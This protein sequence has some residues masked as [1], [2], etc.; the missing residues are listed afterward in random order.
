MRKLTHDYFPHLTG[1]KGN[2][3]YIIRII[4]YSF[5][6]PREKNVKPVFFPHFFTR[7]N[8]VFCMFFSLVKITSIMFFSSLVKRE[9]LRFFPYFTIV[10]HES[11]VL[12]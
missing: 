9:F 10:Y 6:F 5:F 3:L 4:I 12:F 8:N 7:E 2:P 11:S 1:G